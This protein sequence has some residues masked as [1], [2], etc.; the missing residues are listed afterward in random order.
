MGTGRTAYRM[1]H[2]N[3]MVV[4]VLNGQWKHIHKDTRTGDAETITETG[5]IIV[6]TTGTITMIRC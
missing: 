3:I 4:E 5:T 6:F 2:G 1:L